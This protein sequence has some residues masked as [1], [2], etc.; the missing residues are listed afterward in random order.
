MSHL[1]VPVNKCSQ[2]LLPITSI[3]YVRCY[4][5][6]R[7]FHHSPCCS[8][9]ESSHASMSTSKKNDW[10]CHICKPRKSPNNAYK[11][12]VFG[13]TNNSSQSI[14]SP[15]TIP[16]E[17]QNKQ[18]REDD[19]I[20]TNNTKRF[21]EAATALNINNNNSSSNETT[22]TRD[23]IAELKTGM[24]DLKSSLQL[25]AASISSLSIDLK[26]HM[27]SALVEMNKNVATIAAQVVELQKKDKEK[28]EQIDELNKRIQRL[29]QQAI[30]KNIEINN[31]ED[32]DIEAEVLVKRIT[33]SLGVDVSRDHIS[34]TYKIKRKKKIIVEFSTL[35][36]KKELMGKLK[37][38]R[39]KANVAKGEPENESGGYVYI[40]DELT[41]HN[42]R[43]LWAAKMKAKENGWKFVWVRN[44]V[45]YARKNES[46]SLIILYNASDLESI[47]N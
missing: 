39:V 33:D 25:I 1:Q 9:S 17:Q 23:D 6:N 13:G 42:R 43:L 27:D 44:G 46:S 31:V 38:H 40:N 24:V 36:K 30:D 41:M 16:E 4:Q 3:Q 18:Q 8:L 21:K 26:S 32:M 45:I 34:H 2:C 20:N 12:F 19:E 35:N 7:N 14:E 22:N 29:E 11:T 28:S 10:K 37:S 15:K 47:T 5:C